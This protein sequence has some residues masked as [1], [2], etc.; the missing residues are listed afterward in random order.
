MRQR[1]FGLWMVLPVGDGF[2]E[3]K[4]DASRLDFADLASTPLQSSGLPTPLPLW[5][6]LPR[7]VASLSPCHS[8]PRS[9]ISKDL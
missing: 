6:W 9:Q 8:L 7:C 5:S 1:L 4:R 2:R 3:A